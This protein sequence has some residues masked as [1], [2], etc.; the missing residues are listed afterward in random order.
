VK[1]VGVD[2]AYRQA[3]W[4]ALAPGGE[5]A[6]EGRIAA[7]RDV[8][9]PRIPFRLQISHFVLSGQSLAGHTLGS[10]P[11]GGRLRCRA[12]PPCAGRPSL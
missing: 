8:W 1:Y 4:C 2:S 11:V 9:V 5:I 12:F 7:D 10:G 3:Q 6:G